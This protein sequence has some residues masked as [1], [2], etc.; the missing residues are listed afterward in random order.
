MKYQRVCFSCFVYRNIRC[1]VFLIVS[2]LFLVVGCQSRQTVGVYKV[3]HEDRSLGWCTVRMMKTTVG[4]K[5]IRIE[6]IADDLEV[7][8]LDVVNDEFLINSTMRQVADEKYE[9]INVSLQRDGGWKVFR[10]IIGNGGSVEVLYNDIQPTS[11]QG[12]Q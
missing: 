5:S 11:S 6:V 3:I 1:S 2:A 12:N 7:V 8:Q 9:S 4:G 10:G